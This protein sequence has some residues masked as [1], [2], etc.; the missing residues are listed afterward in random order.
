M[1]LGIKM[2]I[3]NIYK[4]IVEK[5]CTHKYFF[6]F[7]CEASSLTHVRIISLFIMWLKYLVVNP[8][9]HEFF[10]SSVFEIY[11]KIG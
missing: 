2:S 8:L 9:L 1:K 7:A 11:P 5:V 6:A 10:F 4:G 3:I